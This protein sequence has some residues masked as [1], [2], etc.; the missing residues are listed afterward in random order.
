MLVVAGPPTVSGFPS[1][2]QFQFSLLSDQGKRQCTWQLRANPARS[3][4]DI[5]GPE[6]YVIDL[7]TPSWCVD[8]QCRFDVTNVERATIG[9]YWRDAQPPFEYSVQALAFR[10][11]S[12]SNA[13]AEIL[14]GV[15]GPSGWCW[16]SV[17]YDSDWEVQRPAQLS[18][19]PEAIS[20][21]ASK[22]TY[23]GNAEGPATTCSRSSR[24]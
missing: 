11:R 10:K 7:R 12:G 6:T 16:K 2:G 21:R 4:N 22:P 17:A 13:T 15:T 14:G 9:S 20:V 18:L 24:K 19:S 1:E 23:F 8:P 5:E 3:A